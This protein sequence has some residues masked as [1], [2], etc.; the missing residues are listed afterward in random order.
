MNPFA[1]TNIL[2]PTIAPDH[3]QA[4]Q[5]RVAG[6]F[7]YSLSRAAFRLIDGAGRLLAR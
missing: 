2:R 7:D 6:D 3:R 5:L 1:V 4:S